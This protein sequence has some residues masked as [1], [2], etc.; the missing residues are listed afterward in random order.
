MHHKTSRLHDTTSPPHHN[1]GIRQTREDTGSATQLAKST[2]YMETQPLTFVYLSTTLFSSTRVEALSFPL[3]NNYVR[4]LYKLYIAGANNTTSPSRNKTT[5]PFSSFV[6]QQ[7]TLHQ[8]HQQQ[9]SQLTHLS[10]TRHATFQPASYTAKTTSPTDLC[11]VAPPY[12]P[13]A[14]SA[15][16]L[17][18]S[19]FHQLHIRPLTHHLNTYNNIAKLLPQYK[20][21]LKEWGRVPHS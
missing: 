5:P 18:E 14:I 10:K 2:P 19:V 3:K 20:W 12:T 21:A 15:T 17:D 4:A 16:F 13:D 11:G 7:M 1:R 9:D 8:Q 6:S